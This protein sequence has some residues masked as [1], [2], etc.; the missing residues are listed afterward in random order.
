MGPDRRTPG[1]EL[2]SPLAQ[3]VPDVASF[4]V[5]DGFTYRIPDDLAISVG[6]LVR[7]PLGGRRVRGFVTALHDRERP[8]LR[9][10]VGRSGDFNVFTPAGLEALR[11]AAFHYVAPLSA[12]LA[13]TAPPNVPK[14]E[15]GQTSAS[16]AG[17]SS[18]IRFL[19]GAGP[20]ELIEVAAADSER[21]QSTV[22]VMPTVVEA[23]A[24]ETE[25]G[26]KLGRGVQLA[27]SSLG[28]KTVTDA[29]VA[30]T[31]APTTLVTTREGAFWPVHNL[32]NAVVVDEARRGH[33]DK[34]MP[35]TH[36]RDILAKRAQLEGFR[37]MMT[38][39]VPSGEALA[40]GTRIQPASARPWG[41][42]EV[43]DR[44][45]DPPG[46]GYFAMSV[47]RAIS[48]VGKESETVF[49]FTRRRG[50]AA[51]FRCVNCRELRTCA[52]CG[53]GSD[54][55]EACRR[56]STPFRP[57]ANCGQDRFEALGS[58]IG[59]TM[60]EL[61]RVTDSVGVVGS[62]A[63]VVVGT[64]QDLPRLDPVRLAVVADADGL[65]LA[66]SYR[67]GEEALRLMARVA[68]AV[69][70]G[71]GRRC[72][73]QTNQPS[74][75]AI[76]AL[77]RGDPMRF[78]EDHLRE[79]SDAGFPPA[80][81]LMVVESAEGPPAMD[82]ELKAAAGSGVQVLGP[83]DINDRQRWLIQGPD[84][85]KLKVALRPLVHSWRDG[86]ARVRVDAD[87]TDI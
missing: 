86:G 78:L 32:A 63:H 64:E 49:V 57:C 4:A 37:L 22:F 5:D 74:H 55:A 8:R 81:Q 11:W 68:S 44:S 67:A 72:I 54:T 6:S 85:L 66:P 7:I 27:T 65:L 59:R 47:K 52:V 82:A 40:T 39:S 17:T 60:E 80:G 83:I 3:V 69:E 50:F 38:G 23:V 33:K 10:I 53:A 43:A 14:S 79:R 41:L 75:P 76:E 19:L 70:P 15:V 35:T 34:R 51:A 21:G 29:W 87:P 24:L 56:C 30:S 12:L 9:Q 46:S 84:L 77:K 45:A 62:G 26:R 73:V 13:K 25:L 48:A 16:G 42:I 2:T 1:Q 36:A 18:S 61:K 28:A 31:S 71:R 58:G 20:P